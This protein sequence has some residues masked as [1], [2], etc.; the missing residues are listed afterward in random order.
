MSRTN[1]RPGKPLIIAQRGQGLAF[2]LPGNPLAHF[3]CLNLHVRVALEAWQ[4][5]PASSLFQQGLLEADLEADGHPRETFWPAVA[6][7][8]GGG[9][10]LTPLRWR[11]SGDLTPL[12]RANALLRV[13]PG[14]RAVP[15]GTGI[16]FAPTVGSL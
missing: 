1:S 12:A 3:V 7:S 15:R 5:F 13:K 10:G 6:R 4:G 2:G 11:G 14:S 8:A 16:E 9:T